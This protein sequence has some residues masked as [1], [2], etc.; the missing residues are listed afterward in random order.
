MP[1]TE[2]DDAQCLAGG[3]AL[4][5]RD[6]ARDHLRREYTASGIISL[7]SPIQG[8]D[9][10]G[11]TFEDLLPGTMDTADEVANREFQRLAVEHAKAF[12]TD[13]SRR[14]KIAFLAKDLGISLAH[15]EVEKAAGCRK[16]VL[17]E[18]Y[19]NFILGIARKMK[20]MYSTDDP[21][22]VRVLT[23]LT[24][25]EITGH[26]RTWADSSVELERLFSIAEA[27]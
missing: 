15:S 21:A 27:T 1:G 9:S 2:R 20:K 10:A 13:M 12:I 25:R 14:E 4:I 24:L 11:L 8:M 17:N 18:S 6:V 23:L 22:S 16:S 7:N 19:Q 5:I 26:V 3:A